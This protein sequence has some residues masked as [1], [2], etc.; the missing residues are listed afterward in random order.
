MTAGDRDAVRTEFDDHG[1]ID[2][3]PQPPEKR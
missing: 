3:Y 2:A 1:R